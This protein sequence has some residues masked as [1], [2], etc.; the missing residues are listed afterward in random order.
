[1]SEEFYQ[2]KINQLNG[3]EIAMSDFKGKAVLI[4]NTA[5][6]CGFT[7]QYKGL[8]KLYKDYKDNG[9]VVIGFPCDQFGNQ[10]PGNSEEIQSFCRD[11]YDVTFPMSKKIEV[12]GLNADPLYKYLKQKLK[13]IMNNSIKWNFTKFLIG[14]DGTPI[15]RFGSKAEPKDIIPFLKTLLKINSMDN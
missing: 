14:P 11:N 10:E 3:K 6:K 2:F 1:M 5:S 15:K 7:Y 12:N 4:V 9:L 13:G 8:E